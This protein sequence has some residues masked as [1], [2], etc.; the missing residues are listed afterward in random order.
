MTSLPQP[1]H[2]YKVM[3]LYKFAALPD[4]EALKGPLAEFC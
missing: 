2:P 4:A 1:N 3:A